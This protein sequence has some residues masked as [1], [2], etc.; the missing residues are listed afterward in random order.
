MLRLPKL[1]WSLVRLAVPLVLVVSFFGI[2][3]VGDFNKQVATSAGGS[4]AK[5]AP[6]TSGDLQPQPAGP[7]ASKVDSF[8]SK[9]HSIDDPTSPWVVVNKQRPLNPKTYAPVLTVPNIPLRLGAASDEMHVSSQMAPALEKLV[10][11]SQTAGVPLML[12][13][14]YRSYGLQ[15]SVYGA[16]VKNYG[17]ATADRESARPGYSEHQTGLAVDLEPTSRTCEIAQC[18]GDMAE[19]KWLAAHAADYGFMIRYPQGKE[20][21]T[22][23]MHEPWHIRYVGVELAKELQKQQ[24]DSLEVF[25]KLGPAANY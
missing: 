18:F 9:L 12:A 13:S 25:F 8:N 22:G 10:N 14:G 1:H 24:I 17:Q 2:L 5:T 16:E 20:S 6:N 21:V 11:D 3:L 4:H 19:G 7:P 15:V 23:Y